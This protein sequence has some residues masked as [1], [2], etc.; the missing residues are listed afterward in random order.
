MAGDQLNNFFDDLFQIDESNDMSKP[1]NRLRRK[2]LPMISTTSSVTAGEEEER[3]AVTDP[4]TRVLL[5]SSQIVCEG[6]SRTDEMSDELVEAFNEST[7]SSLY[8]SSAESTDTYKVLQYLK[9]RV[10]EDNQ[11]QQDEKEDSSS[12]SRSSS[13]RPRTA[14]LP[15]TTTLSTPASDEFL[16]YT[17]P[18]KS[19]VRERNILS[20][21]L[22]E[23]KKEVNP[24]INFNESASSLD[25]SSADSTDA[26]KH[27]AAAKA[28]TDDQQQ[29]QQSPSFQRRKD[30]KLQG[31]TRRNNRLSLP[32]SPSKGGA[33]H[34][35]K[36]ATTSKTQDD[37][38]AIHPSLSPSKNKSIVNSKTKDSRK[39]H[40]PK[41]SKRKSI[42]PPPLL[43]FDDSHGSS[44]YFSSAESTDAYKIA[45]KVEEAHGAG[46]N[47][48]DEDGKEDLEATDDAVEN[49]DLGSK[50][51]STPSPTASRKQLKQRWETRWDAI[52]PMSPTSV[53]GFDPR[54]KRAS[55]D[56]GSPHQTRAKYEESK[57]SSSWQPSSYM[58]PKT[59]S[60]R[61]KLVIKASD[62]T[63]PATTSP[64]SIRISNR[65]SSTGGMPE[66]KPSVDASI[67]ELVHF[68]TPENKSRRK[69]YLEEFLDQ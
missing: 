24:S 51:G 58:S 3:S 41:K 27:A 19:Y 13:Q 44:L 12:S 1:R 45:E 28:K 5:P 10:G 53:R 9:T 37:N 25:F 23:K 6:E 42:P 57:R 48:T 68:L 31:K 40:S 39:V 30:R 63:I 16:S 49:V 17:Q 67:A 46:M 7:A 8:F 18:S 2:S 55:A 62:M 26:Y 29:E 69:V 64:T 21:T 61:Q 34:P 66:K 47:K 43:A 33:K 22:E 59:P 52:F 60:G 56:S 32:A 36:P 11:P 50:T 38:P 15:P 35:T 14:S 4:L 20:R 54:S 65:R